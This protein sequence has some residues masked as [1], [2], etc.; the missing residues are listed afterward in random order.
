MTTTTAAEASGNPKKA[1]K[2]K[3]PKKNKKMCSKKCPKSVKKHKKYNKKILLGG[4]FQKYC[5][6]FY[7]QQYYILPKIGFRIC[8]KINSKQY[9]PLVGL[10][11]SRDKTVFFIIFARNL[12]LVTLILVNFFG[13]LVITRYHEIFEGCQQVE[14]LPTGLPDL[15]KPLRNLLHL[16]KPQFFEIKIFEKK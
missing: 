8:W 4:Q 6:I 3:N 7:T 10:E 1:K 9:F 12:I 11:F 13:F 5:L 15:P 16:R 2:N 14:N